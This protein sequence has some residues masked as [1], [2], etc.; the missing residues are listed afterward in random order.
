[1]RIASAG[2]NPAWRQSVSVCSRIMKTLGP[3]GIWSAN[4]MATFG[5][6]RRASN[7]ARELT[8]HASCHGIL[9]NAGSSN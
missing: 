5:W 9:A 3:T 4:S 7:S 6:R 1:M 2:E 8:M